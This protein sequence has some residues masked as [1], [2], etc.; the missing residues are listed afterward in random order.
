M[1]VPQH[2]LN[3]YCIF[4]PLNISVTV[5]KKLHSLKGKKKIFMTDHIMICYSWSNISE[6]LLWHIFIKYTHLE[7]VGNNELEQMH[8]SNNCHFGGIDVFLFTRY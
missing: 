7:E 6:I 2:P 4:L 3:F 5:V 8:I 1:T